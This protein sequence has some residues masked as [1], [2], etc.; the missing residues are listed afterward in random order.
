LEYG[1]MATIYTWN[2]VTLSVEHDDKPE[3]MKCS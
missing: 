1:Y 3:D 2:K